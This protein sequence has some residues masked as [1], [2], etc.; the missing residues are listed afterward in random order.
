LHDLIE[1]LYQSYS[2]IIVFSTGKALERFESQLS[3]DLKYF[4]VD[5]GLDYRILLEHKVWNFL[6]VAKA[7]KGVDIDVTQWVF[8]DFCQKDAQQL[9]RTGCENIVFYRE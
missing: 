9:F 8:Y 4:V 5:S 7:I 6:A 1:I 3:E 2:K